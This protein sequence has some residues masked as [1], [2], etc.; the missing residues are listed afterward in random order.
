MRIYDALA[1]RIRRSI[2]EGDLKPGEMIGSEYDL[3]RQASIS[4]M[5]A[6][7]ASE[8][9]LDE[10]LI[11]RRPGKGLFVRE[12]HIA[13]RVVQVVVP[14][15]E[16]D[17]CVQIAR[18][19]KTA[20]AERGVQVQVYDAHGSMDLDIE[21]LR[22]LP[23][24]SPQGA[25]IASWHHPRFA[26]VL[27]ELKTHD[28]PF[29][30]VDERLKDIEVPSVV[31]D[32]YGGGYRAGKELIALGHQRIALVGNLV[33]DT[34]RARLEGL[35]DAIADAG[36][37]FDRSLVCDLQVEPNS[38][39]QAAI[40]RCTRQVLARPDRPSAIF[41]SNDAVAADAYRTLRHMQIQIPG[42]LSVVGFDD[43]PMCEYLEPRL[44][45]IRQPSAEL[46][47]AAMEMLLQRIANPRAAVENRVLPTTWVPRE[48]AAAVTK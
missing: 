22:S 28:Y 27:Y 8:I 42:Q 10:G 15:L 18:G 31:A 29:V 19:A 33:A 9:L 5:S 12:N 14:D 47:V 1:E 17:Q 20:G 24:T 7:K 2:V 30:L 34:V 4:R 37:P 36:L 13:T 23:R 25:I 38:N 40:D 43:D 32:N 35:R 11:E 39:W 46:G 16:Y 41:F 48:S 6:R 3:A 44:T 21:V 26:E 45:T